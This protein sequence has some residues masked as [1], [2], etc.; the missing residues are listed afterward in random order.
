[1]NQ[2][3]VDEFLVMHGADDVEIMTCD[4]LEEAFVGIVERFGQQPVALYDREKVLQIFMTRDGMT[5]EQAEEFFDYN[6]QGAW[7]GEGTP[8]FAT[9]AV[10]PSLAPTEFEEPDMP[11][12]PSM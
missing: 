2:D 8:A 7:V 12:F 5:H 6:V 4:G 3:Q 10:R 9:F 11:L 1:M